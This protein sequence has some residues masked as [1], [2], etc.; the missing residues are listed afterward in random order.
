MGSQ[1]TR[2]SA[3][4]ELPHLLERRDET[5]RCPVLRSG[6]V[7]PA[8]AAS[9][10]VEL[11]NASGAL[12]PT[13]AI[14]VVGGVAQ[15]AISQ[16]TLE[17]EDYSLGWWAIWKVDLGDG[18]HTFRNDAALVRARLFPTVSTVDLFRR[19]RSLDPS[20]AEVITRMVPADY[21]DKLDEADI[22]VQLRLI[23]VDNRPSRVF[24][25]SALRQVWLALWIALIFEDLENFENDYGVV[26]ERW[27]GRYETAWN[28][29]TLAYDADDDGQ[30]E[31][32]K[33]RSV[34]RSI[35]LGS[36]G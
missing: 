34:R 27:R 26:A 6:A 11:R 15:A 5:I 31:A 8:I 23:G 10:S 36:R 9:S 28:K 12:V 3:A 18:V 17:A 2:Y 24:S 30:P 33:R 25:P 35:W 16:A 13:G 1:D 7:V 29:L 21:Q 20:N 32:R 14:A 4:F 22:E 19:L